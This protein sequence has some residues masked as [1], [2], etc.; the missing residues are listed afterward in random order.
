MLVDIT[1]RSP[2]Y[3]SNHPKNVDC[4]YSVSI[5]NG[6]PMG[7]YFEDFDVEGDRHSWRW[8]SF[9]SHEWNNFSF[10][11]QSE[12]FLCLYVRSSAETANLVQTNCFKKNS[13]LTLVFWLKR[14]EEISEVLISNLNNVPFLQ[15]QPPGLA[16]YLFIY[17]FIHQFISTPIYWLVHFF[18]FKL[19]QS[20][21]SCKVLHNSISPF[22]FS[23]FYLIH[24]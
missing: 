10:A 1:L 23:F 4:E 7:I 21:L 22:F 16:Y 11:Y 17:L 14:C 19:Y 24:R 20:A 8:D 13:F 2:G 6:G 15:R 3:P 12:S 5:P 18:Y 9:L